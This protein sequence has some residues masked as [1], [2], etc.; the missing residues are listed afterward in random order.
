M[1]FHGDLMKRCFKCGK[2]KTFG[3]FYRMANM[4][5]GHSGKCKEC[6]RA[7]VLANRAA[8]IEHYRQ[9]DR[10]R[11]M[12]PERVAGKKA[13]SSSPGGRVSHQAA[14]RRQIE[15]HPD[16]YKAR[17]AVGNAVRDGRLQRNPCEVCGDPKSEAH[18]ED[19]SKPLNVRWLCNKHHHATHKEHHVNT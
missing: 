15:K 9:Y 5:D 2:E 8:R 3:E 13:Y 11:A 1:T 10:G 18:H 16:K 7:D 19:Y 12:R 14:L 17:V 6:T 4:K